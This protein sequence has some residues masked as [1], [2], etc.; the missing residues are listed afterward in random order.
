MNDTHNGIRQQLQKVKQH[1][2]EHRQH[3]NNRH[4]A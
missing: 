1:Q 3:P 4:P 2:K